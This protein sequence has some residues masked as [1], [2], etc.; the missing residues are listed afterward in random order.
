MKLICYLLFLSVFFFAEANAITI[1]KQLEDAKMEALAN[2][3]FPEIRC[4]VCSGESIADSRA[5]LAKD[6]RALVREKVAE[7][8][9]KDEILQA[10]TSTYGE[11]ILMR[12]PVNES[13]YLLWAGPFI[14]LC[15]GLFRYYEFRYLR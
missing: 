10:L 14:L 13:T 1:E 12:P 9:N 3:I 7:G 8:K 11:Q 4:M 2:E 6:M 5:E 15:I